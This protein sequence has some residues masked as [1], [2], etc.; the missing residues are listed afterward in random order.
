MN[1]MV[2]VCRF[3]S[4]GNLNRDADGF[5][6]GKS[7]FF[8][9]I[10]FQRN[11]FHK[12]HYNIVNAAFFPNVID[13]DDIR[14]HQPGRRLCLD[15]EFGNKI[16][17]FAEFLLQHFDRYKTIQFMV[18]GFIYIRHSTGTDFF[19]NLIPLADYHSDF[20][21]AYNHAPFTTCESVCA[22]T[23][24]ACAY[25]RLKMILFNLTARPLT[26]Q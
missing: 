18:F 26:V 25:L 1:N 9:D 8:F 2:I 20:N 21:H 19:Q 15:A 23:V 3:N 10:F 22:D 17:V 13:I 6:R 16:L 5:F 11:S 7:R 24:S 14:V 4:H 12:F